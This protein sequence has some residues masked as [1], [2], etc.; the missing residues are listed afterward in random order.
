M[1]TIVVRLETTRHNV[2]EFVELSVGVGEYAPTLQVD[3]DQ[4]PS[5]LNAMQITPDELSRIV[6][7]SL[8]GEGR[9]RRLAGDP[10][11]PSR[12]V[13]LDLTTPGAS[14]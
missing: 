8:N 10:V 3:G 13:Q 14:A 4:L 9:R 7:H 6:S 11:D 1:L 12:H 5:L 2:V